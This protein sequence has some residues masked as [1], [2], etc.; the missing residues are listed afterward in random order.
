M[1]TTRSTG[2]GQRLTSPQKQRGLG[3]IGWLVVAGVVVVM[4]SLGYAII[5]SYFEQ[6]TVNGTINDMLKDQGVRMMTPLEIE[7]SLEKRFS[8]NRIDVVKAK[9]IAIVRTNNKITLH[10]DYKVEKPL[11]SNISVV[12]HFD[13]TYEKSVDN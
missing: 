12:I 4:G 2:Q 1:T 6:A 9:D 10:L 13:K 5:P 8:V 11:F 7:K 3:L